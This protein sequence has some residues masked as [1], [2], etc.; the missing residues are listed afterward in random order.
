[1]STHA[2]EQAIAVSRGVLENVKVDQLGDSTPCTGWNVGGLIDHMVGANIFFSAGVAGAPPAGIDAKFS[3]G[4]YLAAYDEHSAACVA[5]FQGDGV[6]DKMLTLPFGAMPGSAFIGLA[7][8]DTFT[9]AWDLAKAT[10]QSTDLAPDLAELFI[11]AS[12]TLG[13]SK[14]I[15]VTRTTHHKCGRCWRHL[16]DVAE[17]GALCSRCDHVVSAM[18]ASV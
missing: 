14:G 1:M 13:S 2:L 8:I 18:D 16:P 6:M 15:A 7:M 11:T 10:A 4:D 5:A 9:H 3:E 12:V 17:D